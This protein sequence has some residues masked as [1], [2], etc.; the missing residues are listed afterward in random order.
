MKQNVKK[1]SSHA[2]DATM[3]NFEHF[4][5]GQKIIFYR[6]GDKKFLLLKVAAEDTEFYIKYVPW[7]FA[8]GRVD[9]GEDV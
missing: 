9:K 6:P 7:D 8:G 4:Q 1:T 3:N 5:L 2:S